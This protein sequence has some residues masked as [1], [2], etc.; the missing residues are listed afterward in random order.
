MSWV[1]R[2]PQLNE[3]VIEYHDEFQRSR[4]RSLQAVDEMVESLVKT[5][6]A[7]DLLENTYVFYTTDNG[8]HISQHRLPPGKEC[9]F[10]TDIHIPPA[11]RG[12]GVP[13][14]HIAGVISSHT[15][16]TPTMLKI[17]G[18]DRLPQLDGFPIPL[19]R[20]ALAA[21]ESSEHVNVEFWGRAV[22]EGRYGWIGNDTFPAVWNGTAPIAV[23]N[24]TYKALCL[25]CSHY[26]LLY[27]VWCTGER[28]FY[29]VEVSRSPRAGEESV[30]SPVIPA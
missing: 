20:S 27:T 18:S 12:P 11:V 9:P 14:G 13:A 29:D 24:N 10:E 22:P 23:R 15:D 3:T 2:L 1:R 28:E 16:L 7:K 19:T 25:V 30:Y 17:A 6:D 21:P 26:N 5:L 8:Y 4:L